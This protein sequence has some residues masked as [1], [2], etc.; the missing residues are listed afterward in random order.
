[1][2]M[3][4][5]VVEKEKSHRLIKAFIRGAPPDAVGRVFYGVK[6]SNARDW[7]IAQRSGEPWYWIDNSYFDATR[8][9]RFRVTK[10][11]LQVNARELD[12]DCKRF[13]ALG[14]EIRPWR[15]VPAGY[16]LAVHQSDDHS[17]AAPEHKRWMAET[18]ADLSR[19]RAVVH[20]QWSANKVALSDTLSQALDGAYGVVTH[21]SA[22]AV[23]AALAGITCI[24]HES[25]ALAGMVCG[26]GEYAHL[27]Q[28]R[29]FFGVLADHE[30]TVAELENGTAWRALNP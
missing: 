18:V 2:L 14:L 26:M 10:N 5:P 11:R 28:R 12:S 25:H 13:D 15:S 30:F 16:W 22:A 17:Y 20:R 1:M 4:C 6:A 8:G 29:R 19:H 3:G 27:D 21:T 7:Q 9:Q 23:Q 24:V